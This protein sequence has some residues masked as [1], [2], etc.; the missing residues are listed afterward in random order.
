MGID[1]WRRR[2]GLT[3]SRSGEKV[4]QSPVRKGSR[5]LRLRIESGAPVARTAVE[6][7]NGDAD[8][9]VAA[10]DVDQ[11]VWESPK[12]VA[13]CAVEIDAPR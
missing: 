11:G 10:F 9:A 12:S 6:M 4:T 2:E 3:Q 13:T 7:G 5:T 8:D 1:G